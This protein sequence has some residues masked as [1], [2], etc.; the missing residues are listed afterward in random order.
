MR[1]RT[2]TDVIQCLNKRAAQ[3]LIASK[4]STPGAQRRAQES[5]GPRITNS[6]KEEMKSHT[7]AAHDREGAA[8]RRLGKA[9]LRVH[10]PQKK[11]GQPLTQVA[12]E[13]GAAEKNSHSINSIR[14]ACPTGTEV[15]TSYDGSLNGLNEKPDPPNS[16]TRRDSDE[17]PQVT[18]PIDRPKE[19]RSSSSPPRLDRRKHEPERGLYKGLMCVASGIDL[20]LTKC[21]DTVVDSMKCAYIETTCENW[22]DG[23]GASPV[24]YTQNDNEERCVDIVA[25]V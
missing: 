21:A 13:G 10:N 15:E 14:W 9:F 3:I 16:G 19:N 12:L 6:T 8:R 4:S 11:V 24:I 2:G 5:D 25:R 1:K 7:R 22:S 20:V 18:V 23:L 17:E